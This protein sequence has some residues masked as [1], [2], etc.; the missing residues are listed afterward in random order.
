[1]SHFVGI[2]PPDHIYNTILNIQT[3]FG[4]NRLEPHITVIPP[5][6]VTDLP[7]WQQAIE[8]ICSAFPTFDISLPKTG[9]FGKR[10]LFIDVVSEQLKHLHDKM[11]E[12]T[13]P[14]EKP[15]KKQQEERSFR[16]HLTLGRSWC[17]FTT[18][19]F[20]AMKSLAEEYLRSSVSFTATSVRIYHKPSPG[21]RYQP[22][23]DVSLNGN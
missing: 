4:D 5:V 21:G 18:N 15:S 23:E 12:A 16:P 20:A 3:Q 9:K 17:G 1:M 22:L 8:D 6:V 2:V 7:Q 11:A 13:Q 19:S 14:F 10:V